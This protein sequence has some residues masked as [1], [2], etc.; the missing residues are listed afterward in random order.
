MNVGEIKYFLDMVDE[1]MVR[2]LNNTI[3]EIRSTIYFWR[4][5]P[6]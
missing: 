3:A 6:K 1:V 2:K 4:Q 5:E